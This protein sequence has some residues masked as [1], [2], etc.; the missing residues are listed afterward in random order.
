[1]TA[2]AMVPPHRLTASA[3]S[4]M[5]ASGAL[6]VEALAR[7]CLDRVAARD[8]AV[9][10]W[11]FVDPA[12]VLRQARELDKVPRRGPL[13]GIPIGIKDVIDTADMPTCHNSPHYQ[14]HRPGADAACVA[15]LR[16]A[17]ALILG[18]TDTTEFAA[19]GRWAA[20]GNPHDLSRTSGGS[21]SGSAAA[22]ADEHVPLALGTQ[23]GGSLIRPASFC[24]VFALK[25]TWGLVSREGAKLYS[26]TL[27]TIGWYGRSVADLRLLAELFGLGA[28]VPPVSL[29]DARIGLCRSPIWDLAEPATR[30]A[31]TEAADRLAA[32][33]ADLVPLDL[34]ASFR[35]M[36]TR[37]HRTILHSEGR[38]AFLSLIRTF[39]DAVHDDF[40]HRV[41]NR[42][43][44]THEMLRDAYDVAARCRAE[45][46]TI[47]KG[48]TAVLTPS[49]VGEAPAGRNP[50]NPVFNQMWTLLH[51]PC[52]NVPSRRGPHGLPVGVTLTGPRFSDQSLLATAESVAGCLQG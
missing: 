3:A 12:A 1:M 34:P 44:F 38:A 15:T 40:R 21:S 48:F 23:T 35:D 16:A 36:P 13:H 27:D 25:P 30:D 2:S 45:F 20:T 42:D 47:A 43:G 41:E 39:G 50:G 29:R 49:A 33:G 18:K 52:V 51:V 6:K 19:A 46:D 22:V 8:P 26:L 17:G 14:G 11:A 9:R 10:A 7:D 37:V 28:A 24:G 32:A 31:F 4:A 5:I